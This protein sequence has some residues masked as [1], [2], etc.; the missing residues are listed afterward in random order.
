MMLYGKQ[1][2]GRSNKYAFPDTTKFMDEKP[3][4]LAGTHVFDYGI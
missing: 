4:L 2:I 1:A 3:L